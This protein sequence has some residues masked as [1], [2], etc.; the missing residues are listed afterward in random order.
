M[1]GVVGRSVGRVN[2]T[3]G[4]VRIVA[5]PSDGPVAV[6]LLREYAAGIV[7]RFYGREATPAE[8]E[9]PL[10]ESTPA[11]FEAPRGAF[12][13]AYLDDGPVG[14]VGVRHLDEDTSELK[15]LYVRPSA[16]GLGL[17]AA[18]TGEVE[19]AARASGRRR[20]CLD[21]RSDLVE[22]RALYERLG[23][24]ETEPYGGSAWAEHWYAKELDARS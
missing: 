16:R 6:S 19:R 17:G 3:S 7:S 24:V 15:R 11:D 10:A 23:Y 12:F 1:V 21:T 13:V 8:I 5:E 14:C 20:V 9:L 4:Q 22:A 2:R 18:L